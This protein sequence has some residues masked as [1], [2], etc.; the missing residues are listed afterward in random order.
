M[1]ITVWIHDVFVG[2][3]QTTNRI[4][5]EKGRERRKESNWFIIRNSLIQLPKPRSLIL[6]SWGM[7]EAG[8]EIQLG[9]KVWEGRKQEKASSQ[10]EED[11]CISSNREWVH[12]TSTCLFCGAPAGFPERLDDAHSR[13]A[14][15]SALLDSPTQM[16]IS[17]E[18]PSQTHPELMFYP[19][20]G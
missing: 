5:W 19:L 2:V 4:S 1:S 7:R 18:V 9:L 20:S 15:S 3:T 14:V 8:V 13:W 10:A 12:P 11:K 16:L 17:P 6:W